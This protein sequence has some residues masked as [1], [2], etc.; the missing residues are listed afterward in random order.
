[1]E[2]SLTSLLPIAAH[3]TVYFWQFRVV[4]EFFRDVIRVFV[5]RAVLCIGW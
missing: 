3:K 4:N 2:A 1:M 5:S